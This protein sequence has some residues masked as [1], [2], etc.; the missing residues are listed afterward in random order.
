MG[1]ITF[2]LLNNLLFPLLKSL[3]EGKGVKRRVSGEEFRVSATTTASQS[4][5]KETRT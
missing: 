1:W 3:L 5:Q 2:R 4:Q